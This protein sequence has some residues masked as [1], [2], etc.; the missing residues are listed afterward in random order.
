MIE[1]R[2]LTQY[3][4]D[5]FRSWLE[6]GE[7]PEPPAQ[8][9]DGS[10]HTELAYSA[11][12]NPEET[13][14][15]RYSFGKYLDERLG[16]F[17]FKELMSPK[18]DGLWAWFAV[19]YFRQLSAKGRR[20]SEHYLVIRKGSIGSLAY[21]QAARSSFE[22][23]HI[24]GENSLVCLSVGMHTFGD[25]AEQLASRQTLAH[26][27]GFFET[28]F[29]LYVQDG[30]LKRG[31]SSKPKTLKNRKP[32][33]RTGLGGARRLATALQRLDL[34]FDTEVMG[35]DGIVTVLPREFVKWTMS[36]A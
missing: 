21:R 26:N 14:A 20:R 9:V 25:M 15:S 22:L 7:G 3:G 17:D 36:S 1:V 16:T 18:N 34:T 6:T 4:I 30:K 27:H 8:L 10:E 24:H 12:V 31:A 28:A 19:I 33:D 35:S 29:A 13:F 5:S 23:V 32:G 2:R 11:Q